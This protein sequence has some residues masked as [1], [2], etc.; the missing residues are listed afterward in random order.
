MER[1]VTLEEWMKTVPERLTTD[2]LWASA[3]YRLGMY[4]YDLAW[5]DC[6]TL[7]RDFRGHE[8][9]SQLIRS[10]GGLCANVEEAYGRGVGTADYVRILR[11]ALGETREAQGWYLRSRHILPVDLVDRR[12]EII[13]QII[14]LLVKTISSH[15]INLGKSKLPNS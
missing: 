4:L 3:Y 9:V 11:I 15:R 5:L 1:E 6:V 2:P 10:T 12:L 13:T 14:S 8:L 7:R